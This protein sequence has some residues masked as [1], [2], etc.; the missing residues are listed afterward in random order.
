MEQLRGFFENT[1][2]EEL[3]R[4]ACILTA[5]HVK[6]SS[7]AQLYR[8]NKYRVPMSDQVH[9]RLFH[10]LERDFEQCGILVIRILSEH[11][12]IDQV[13]RGPLEPFSFEAIYRRARHMELDSVDAQEGIPG[14]DLQ[15]GLL[16]KDILD[17]SAALKLGPLPLEPDLRADVAAELEEED[18]INPPKDGKPTL[19][20]EFNSM[21]PIKQESGDSPERT[22]IPYPPSRARDVVVEMQKVKENRDRFRIEGRTGGI[23]PAVSACMFTFHNT[24]GR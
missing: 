11:C 1:R 12:T 17:N 14:A 10:F 7:V 19:V 2:K 8:N 15:S 6:E 16:N 23:G 4:L 21:H 5:Q 13:K 18:R 22:E 20:D 3:A 24:L 9:G